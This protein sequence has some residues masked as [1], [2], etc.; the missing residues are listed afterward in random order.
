MKPR[1]PRART[2][3]ATN[4]A[5]ANGITVHDRKEKIEDD[6]TNLPGYL[7]IDLE[8]FKSVAC[9]NDLVAFVNQHRGGQFGDF[10]F[11]IHEQNQFAW[12]LFV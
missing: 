3:S 8:G 10:G 12:P 5:S 2:I 1:K 11:V 7:L 6:K 9:E 4:H